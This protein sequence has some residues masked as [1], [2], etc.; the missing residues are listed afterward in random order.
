[1]AR[2]RLE[3]KEWWPEFLQLKDRMPL[4]ELATRFGVSV[5][6]LSRALKRAGIERAPVRGSSAPSK[7]AP[8]PAR[9]DPRSAEAQEWWPEFLQ[10]KD[11]QSLA[12][13]AKKFGVAEITLQ[14]ALKRTGV[15]RRSQRGARGGRESRRA[16]RRIKPFIELLG[17]LP[18]GDIAERAGVSRYAVAQYRKRRDIPSVREPAVGEAPP[19]APEPAPATG[20]TPVVED[21]TS[22]VVETGLQA[23]RV[24]VVVGDADRTFV[25]VGRDLA[26]AA[27]LAQGSIGRLLPADGW[28]IQRMEFVGPA[29]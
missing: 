7:A 12:R 10:L 5:N 6:G 26:D 2:P 16:A 4:K 3:S 1:V 11:K 9:V 19:H 27:G 21:P 28:R 17:R 23:F 8:Q 15:E 20:S 29:L 24:E 25:V 22:P 13:L 18:D 14:R